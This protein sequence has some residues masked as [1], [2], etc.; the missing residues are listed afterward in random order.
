M[1]S[2]LLLAAV[3]TLA[4]L[5]S[6]CAPSATGSAANTPLL[7][8]AGDLTVKRGETIYVRVDYQL[9]DFGLV[10]GDLRASLWIPSGYDSEVGDVSNQ[11]GLVEPRVAD[12]WQF[13]LLQMRAE[14]KSVRGSGAFDASRTVYSLWAVYRIDAPLEAIPGP[15]RLRGALNARG[16]GSQSVSVTVEATP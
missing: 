5:V 15:Y 10:P 14:R 11:F 6:G 3:A 1:N 8:S 7:A 9:T 16:A 2:R 4:L 13:G 12:G